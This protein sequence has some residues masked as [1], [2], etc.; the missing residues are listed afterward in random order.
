MRELWTVSMRWKPGQSSNTAVSAHVRVC[1]G[2]RG[3]RGTLVGPC[4][5]GCLC[6]GRSTHTGRPEVNRGLFLGASLFE[7]GSLSCLEFSSFARLTG[8]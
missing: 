6:E 3:A 5:Q 1:V 7:T 8:Q 4:S 2:A